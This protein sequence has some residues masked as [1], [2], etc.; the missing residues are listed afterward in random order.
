M[1]LMNSSQLH[2]QQMFG[3]FLV[4]ICS[5]ATSVVFAECNS[6]FGELLGWANGVPA[7]SNCNDDTTSNEFNQLLKRRVHDLSAQHTGHWSIDAE[8]FGA[9]ENEDDDQDE[10]FGIGMKWQCVEYARR[11]LLAR[12]GTLFGSVDSAYQIWNYRRAIPWDPSLR[13]VDEVQ[14]RAQK[15]EGVP[16][17]R[18]ANKQ[19][20]DPPAVNDILLWQK[21]PGMPHG[22]VA[23]VADVEVNFS[24]LPELWILIAE[25]NYA[26]RPWLAQNYS[27]KLRVVERESEVQQQLWKPHEDQN[28]LSEAVKNAL[29]GHRHPHHS[30]RKVYE[31]LDPD[32]GAVVI[33]WVR[34]GKVKDPSHMSPDEL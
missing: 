11:Y 32:E 17:R 15:G 7:F 24:P 23:I 5:H 21:G 10:T 14:E 25:Q 1:V 9:E 2:S 27:R 28:Q 6:P 34:V 19:A 22:H 12:R 33:G 26:N 18:L 4:L 8:E 13:D 3:V 29:L 30:H 31:I 20:S 16:L